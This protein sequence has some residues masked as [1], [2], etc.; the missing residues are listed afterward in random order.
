[1]TWRGQRPR[2][3]ASP[4]GR[5]GPGPAPYREEPPPPRAGVGWATYA[6]LHARILDARE[7]PEAAFDALRPV[8]DDLDA[9]Q[10]VLLEEPAAAAGL[11]RLA[12]ARGDDARAGAVEA[13]ATRL[14]NENADVESLAAAA[15]HSSGVR[16]G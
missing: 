7:G 13:R 14:A 9:H 6:W 1:M 15:A 4:R 2:P 3:A 8:Y 12:R 5:P 10:R 16:R 11:V